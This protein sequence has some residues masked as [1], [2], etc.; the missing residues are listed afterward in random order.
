MMSDEEARQ[1]EWR[2]RYRARLE[3]ELEELTADSRASEADRSP[4]TLD[5]QS[6]GRLSR[7]DD[8]R[9]QA[10]AAASEQRR[11]VR[12]ARIHSALS[13]MADGEYGYCVECGEPVAERRLDLDPTVHLCVDCAR[14]GEA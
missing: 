12:I 7:M 10:M 1:D 6:V 11:Q 3:K 2:E 5:Q 13:R 9:S 4:V 8:I 14:R